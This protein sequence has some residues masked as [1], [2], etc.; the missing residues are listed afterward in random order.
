MMCCKTL[1]IKELEKP[2]GVWCR[3]AVTGKGCGIYENRPPVCQSFYCHWM[4]NPHLGPEWK[5]DKAKFV[6]YGDAPSGDRQLIHIAVDPNFP[7]AWMKPPFFA[8]IK[9]WVAD[10]AARDQL[11][12]VLVQI[13]AR[14]IGVLPDRIVELG[15]LDPQIPLVLSRKRGPAGYTYEIRR[16]EA[17]PDAKESSQFGFRLSGPPAEC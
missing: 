15:S 12:L 2:P 8:A 6:L 13:G 11:L 3:H 4:L 1:A 16:R 5:P 14:F 9:K 17:V 7:D 10:G